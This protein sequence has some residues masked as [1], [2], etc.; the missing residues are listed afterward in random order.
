MSSG[1]VGG[2][3]QSD[4]AD[5][6]VVVDKINLTDYRTDAFR[7]RHGSSHPDHNDAGHVDAELQAPPHLEWTQEIHFFRE[8]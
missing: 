2:V 5:M 4:V 3:T 1:L 6:A 7:H 8:V